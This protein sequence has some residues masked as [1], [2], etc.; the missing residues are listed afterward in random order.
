MPENT[1]PSVTTVLPGFDVVEGTAS[2]WVIVRNPDSPDWLLI[3]GGYPGDA[4]TVKSSL[5]QLGCAPE[6]CKGILVT[7][8][9]VDHIGGISWLANEFDVPVWC[10]EEEV[11]NLRGPKREQVTLGEVLLRIARP[12]VLRW[13]RN[14]VKHG[15]LGDI[16]LE[17]TDTFVDSEVLA[18]PRSPQAIHVPGH[19]SGSAA[20]LF[21]TDNG[22]ILVSGD[23]LVTDHELLPRTGLA[24]TLPKFFAHNHRRAKES[25]KRLK[26]LNADIVIPG[27]GG[28]VWNR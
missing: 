24:R 15:A 6:H 12:R 11:S 2:N 14:I 5:A 25:L 26:D 17:P 19:T 9:H 10:H 13:L 22:K 20:Y 1:S 27:H 23:A 16:S 3:D 4:D 7:H 18:L 8:G 21:V 28:V